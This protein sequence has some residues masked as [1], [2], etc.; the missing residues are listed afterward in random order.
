[1]LLRNIL[2]ILVN[3][4]RGTVSVGASDDGPVVHFPRIN[5]KK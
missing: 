4:L 5:I 2:D 1:M 3:G